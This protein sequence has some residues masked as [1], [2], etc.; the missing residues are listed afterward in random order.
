MSDTHSEEEIRNEFG[1]PDLV[2]EPSL[3]ELKAQKHMDDMANKYW[4][5]LS[6]R[7]AGGCIVYALYDRG[8]FVNPSCRWVVAELTRRLTSIRKIG[9]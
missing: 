9:V 2:L 1:D 4:I 6:G 5:F 7:C 8:W 3:S